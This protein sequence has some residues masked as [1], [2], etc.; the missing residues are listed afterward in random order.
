MSPIME[1]FE[2]WNQEAKLPFPTWTESIWK[3]IGARMFLKG[4]PSHGISFL[5]EF[6]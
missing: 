3:T 5:S 4:N 6:Q 2:S 1:D